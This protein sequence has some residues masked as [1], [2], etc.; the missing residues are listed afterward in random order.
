MTNTNLPSD[1]FSENVFLNF[2]RREY[3]PAFSIM[4]ANHYESGGK[5]YAI[6]TKYVDAKV[7]FDKQIEF[8]T[9]ESF[10]EFVWDA[11]DEA[12][13]KNSHR[14]LFG[15]FGLKANNPHRA[16]QIYYD[17]AIFCFCS[18]EFKEIANN[19]K[20]WNFSRML[21]FLSHFRYNGFY[22]SENKFA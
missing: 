12:S 5:L 17:G 13:S 7:S 4:V 3:N 20:N 6:Y 21:S 8:P 18:D 1:F 2:L 9:I 11:F 10:E 15:P 22:F 19:K 16:E 14:F